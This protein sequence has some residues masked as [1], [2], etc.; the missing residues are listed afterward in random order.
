MDAKLLEGLTE[1]QIA[2]V[3]EF[4]NH[5]ELL[6][7]ASDEGIELSEEQLEAVSGGGACSSSGRK[8]VTCKSTNI[9]LEYSR[10]GP[11][12]RDDYYTCNDC[13]ERWY[14]RTSK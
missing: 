13:H 12:F 11:V 1:E 4:K 2:K 7:V 5:E 8:C 6:K 9:K 10:I 3:K 14:V